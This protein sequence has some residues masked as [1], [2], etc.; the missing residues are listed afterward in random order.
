VFTDS[1]LDS[2][3]K[4]LD[5]AFQ[6]K[7]AG[8]EGKMRVCARRAAGFAAR[9]FLQNQGITI[10]NANAI[11]C[12]EQLKSTKIPL[13]CILRVDKLIQRV[14]TNFMLPAEIDLYTEASALVNEL[15][16]LD[17]GDINGNE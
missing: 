3:R 9:N 2:I 10:I 11:H 8:N 12:L 7:N 17:K 5:A 14:D 13:T 15:I 6:A 16:A 1:T 4:E